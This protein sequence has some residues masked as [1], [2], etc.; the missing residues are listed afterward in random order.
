MLAMKQ[1]LVCHDD[2]VI[3]QWNSFINEIDNKIDNT[4]VFLR[5]I[6]FVDFFKEH[7]LIE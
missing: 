1:I 6:G 2:D 7:L 3:S 5:K 4:I